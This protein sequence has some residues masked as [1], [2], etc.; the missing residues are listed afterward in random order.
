MMLG[1]ELH[2]LIGNLGVLCILTTYLLLQLERI[3][4][5]SVL[6]SVLNALGS[7][8][9]VY[10]LLFEFNLSAF[11]VELAW[12]VISVFGLTRRFYRVN[13]S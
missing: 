4:A 3:V 11:I 5:T 6:Y 9:I 1:Y 2:D 7:G 13:H 8:M 10:S 12:L